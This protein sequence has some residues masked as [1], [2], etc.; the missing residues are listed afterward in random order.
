[1]ATTSSRIPTASLS[2]FRNLNGICYS[3][4]RTFASKSTPVLKEEELNKSVSEEVLR[5]RLIF[6]CKNRGIKE[7]DLM[8][9][10]WAMEYV[11]KL[12]AEQC[13]ELQTILNEETL[14]LV[15]ILLKREAVPE[16]L[17][18]SVMRKLVEWRDQ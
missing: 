3:M 18:N 11:D 4:H 1:M 16:N 12:S 13:K 5:R 9:G 2:R 17:E 7:L 6:R 15:N 14:D 10:N 8:M